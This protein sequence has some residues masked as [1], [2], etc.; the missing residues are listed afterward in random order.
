MAKRHKIQYITPT[1]LI[2]YNST[3]K[4][5]KQGKTQIDFVPK[6]FQVQPITFK[7]ISRLR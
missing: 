7:I 5:I 1:N 4:R 2:S 3:H 6:L